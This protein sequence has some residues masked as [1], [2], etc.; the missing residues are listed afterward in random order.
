MPEDQ[1]TR[2]VQRNYIGRHRQL[3]E[4]DWD[5]IDEQNGSWI[6]SRGSEDDIESAKEI[7]RQDVIERPYQ[8]R[9]SIIPKGK[10]EA[11]FKG[12]WTCL[13]N[14]LFLYQDKIVWLVRIV[15]FF[16]KI[17]QSGVVSL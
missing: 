17:R 10:V 13:I 12:F 5:S 2:T 4:Y 15:W 1:K 14:Q 6:D 9:I 8:Q 16:W 11:E 7:K 3:P